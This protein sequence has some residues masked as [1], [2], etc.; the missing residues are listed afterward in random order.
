[1]LTFVRLLTIEDAMKLKKIILAVVL[2]MCTT[3]AEAQSVAL[4]TNLLY[5][6][7]ATVNLGLEFGLTKRWTLDVSG[8]INAWE[9]D[10]KSWKHVMVQPEVRYWFCDRFAGWFLG[11]HAHGGAYNVGNITNDTK[12]LGTDFSELSDYRFEGW[13]VGGGLGIGYAW[14][15]GT[16][17]NIEAEIG[18]GYSFSMFDKF[19]CYQCGKKVKEDDTY[20]YFGITK[21]E[22]GVVYVF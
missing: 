18:A 3:I 16:H 5:D 2:L 22:L 21:V 12:F 9:I 8:N 15:L 4:K 11:V 17:W 10:D 14:V 6:A 13:F 7:T 20:N 1:M 19:E